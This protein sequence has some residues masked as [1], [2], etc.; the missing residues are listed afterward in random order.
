MENKTKNSR[1]IVFAKHQVSKQVKPETAKPEI[2]VKKP[3]Q[4]TT[5]EG[6]G[7]KAIAEHKLQHKVKKQVREETVSIK[8][9]G[10]VRYL[11]IWKTYADNKNTLRITD[12]IG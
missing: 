8:G 2:K 6:L 3:T 9:Y 1:P 12:Y 7:Y 5:E 4:V 11:A 10:N